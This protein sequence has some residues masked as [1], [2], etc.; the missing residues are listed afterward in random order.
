MDRSW[1]ASTEVES[2][3]GDRNVKN[4]LA[5]YESSLDHGIVEGEE[6]RNELN[7]MFS[8]FIALS[9]NSGIKID[10]P[11]MVVV[12]MQSDGKSSFIEGLLGFQFNLVDTGIGTRR[13]LVIEM[14]NDPSCA[15]P[16]CHFR[17][18]SDHTQFEPS[19]TLVKDLAESIT[20]RTNEEAGIEKDRVSHRPIFL[21]VRYKHCATLTIFDTPGFRLSGSESLRNDIATMVLNLVSPPNRIIVCLEQS[22]VE[23]ANSASR[24]I[25]S[26]VDPR[27]ERTI[28]VSTKFD[29]RVKEFLVADAANKFLGGDGL[30]GEARPFF[31]SLPIARNIPTSEFMDHIK[32]SYLADL[33]RLLEIGFDEN[34]F[35]DQIGLFKLKRHLER[36]LYERQWR[37]LMPLM[38]SIDGEMEELAMKTAEEERML[39]ACDLGSVRLEALEFVQL[40]FQHFVALMRGSNMYDTDEF[41]QTLEEE[42]K[43]SQHTSWNHSTNGSAAK[44]RSAT[45][46]VSTGLVPSSTSAETPAPASSTTPRVSMQPVALTREEAERMEMDERLC[47]EAQIKR[48]T[49]EFEAVI[50]CISFDANRG[51]RNLQAMVA[52]GNA[53]KQAQ[54]T[55]TNSTM[56]ELACNR[57]RLSF[58][59]AIPVLIARL[60]Y[61]LK[62]S[63]GVAEI[64]TMRTIKEELD[65]GIDE[66]GRRFV[67]SNAMFSADQGVNMNEDE[68]SLMNNVNQGF[69][70]AVRSSMESFLEQRLSECQK[71]LI[72]SVKV[73]TDSEGWCQ[74]FGSGR[75]GAMSSLVSQLESSAVPSPASRFQMISTGSTSPSKTSTSRGTSSADDN[76]SSARRE[77]DLFAQIKDFLCCQTTSAIFSMVIRPMCDR[78]AL[79]TYGYINS[80]SDEQLESI[81]SLAT[82]EIHHQLVTHRDSL[83][84]L[85]A[86]KED[87]MRFVSRVRQLQ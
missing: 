14:A 22:T 74:R 46:N 72:K 41:G 56:S 5:E 67:L 39:K 77:E 31:I 43:E 21:R 47:G 54:S 23:W 28:L 83:A 50:R 32:R 87:L 61:L 68:E 33:Q 62:R 7:Q 63:F 81:F 44:R 12:G 30:L 70:N 16:I 15:S 24:P 34:R 64:L 9:S 80:L 84:K 4:K 76:V 69:L 3:R 8:A 18:E 6:G 40:L 59:P 78:L 10:V 75:N 86:F 29:N 60:R 66:S 73:S 82:K 58:K 55:K 17:K 53:M 57:A 71:W 51:D 37:S 52:R 13:P 20:K 65:D 25:I 2:A 36:I 85:Q 11:E 79:S 45:S 27:M 48:L 35:G 1:P 26:R 19:A 49:H 42:R 38:R